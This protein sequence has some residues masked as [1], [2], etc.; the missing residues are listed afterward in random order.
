MTLQV[1]VYTNYGRANQKRKSI[2][3]R[4]TKS[5]ETFTVANIRI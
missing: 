1:D 3:L 5:K 2:T 4:L